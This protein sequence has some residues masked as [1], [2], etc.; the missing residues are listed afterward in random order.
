[1]GI[2]LCIHVGAL[3]S[4]TWGTGLLADPDMFGFMVMVRLPDGVLP[5]KKS[6]SQSSQVPEKPSLTDDH[7]AKMQ[8]ILHYDFKVEVQQPSILRIYGSKRT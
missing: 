1:L 2:F 8:D 7:A 5:V 3:L 4:T 6:D